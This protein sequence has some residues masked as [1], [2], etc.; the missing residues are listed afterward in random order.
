[1]SQELYYRRVATVQEARNYQ[2]QFAPMI[3]QILNAAPH[4]VSAG[5]AKCCKRKRAKKTMVFAPSEM[6]VTQTD[7]DKHLIAARQ[8][9]TNEVEQLK[10]AAI[11]TLV[12]SQDN[13]LVSAPEVV[14][15]KIQRIMDAPSAKTAMQEIKSAFQEIKAQHTISFVSHLSQAVK[16]S[17]AAVGF[18]EI[19]VQNPHDT[20]VRII[21]TN[22]TGQNLIA[23]IQT[24]TPT[25]IRTELI[26]FTD[27]SCKHVM[28]TFDEEMSKRGVS[29]KQKKQKPTLGIPQ[30]PYAQKLLKPRREVIERSFEDERVNTSAESSDIITIK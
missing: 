8:Q 6:H 4:G 22:P 16:E 15:T 13:L 2:R 7:F 1:M 14:T 18:S 12:K 30:M 11:A 10:V 25:D 24:G 28:R 29:T 23:E 9:V 20:L 19:R 3:S 5:V 27:G 26:G 21:A 17:A